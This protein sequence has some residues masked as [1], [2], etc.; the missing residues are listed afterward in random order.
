[1][2]LQQ[3]HLDEM[4][5]DFAG[6]TLQRYQACSRM[7]DSPIE[8]LMLWAFWHGCDKENERFG[9]APGNEIP[10]QCPDEYSVL[11]IKQ[12]RIRQY[13]AD[14]AILHEQG[15]RVVVECDGHDYHERT[16]KQAE[17]DRSRDRAMQDLGWRVMR[18]TGSEI[19]R[20]PISCAE[21]VLQ[22]IWRMGQ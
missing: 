3:R 5:A 8:A 19:Y 10:E 9:V 4:M 17:H 12:A 6:H 22:S 20:S 14:F 11:V 15:A 18:F 16:R 7:T 1:M 13:K 2:I 21:Q